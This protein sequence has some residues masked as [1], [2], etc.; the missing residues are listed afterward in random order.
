L[1]NRVPRGDVLLLSK[2]NFQ[3][4]PCTFSDTLRVGPQGQPWVA[5]MEGLSTPTGL[6][7]TGNGRDWLSGHRAATP[8]GL[9]GRAARSPRVATAPTLGFAAQPRWG[10]SFVLA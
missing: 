8:L 1:K 6:W 9:R 4:K 5:A 7:P 3:K 10:W 2:K